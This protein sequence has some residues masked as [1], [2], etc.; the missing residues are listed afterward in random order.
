MT[1]K[2]ERMP[3]VAFRIMEMVFRIIDVFSPAEE[4]LDG[5]DI[6]NGDI[7]VDYGC[8]PGR[9][10]RRASELVGKNG[11]VYAVDIHELAIKAVKKKIDR[12]KLNNVMAVNVKGYE[13]GIDNKS[14]DLIYALD[15]FHMINNPNAF[16]REIHRVLKSTGRLIIDDGHQKRVVSREKINGS[17]IWKI[18]KENK[19]YLECIPI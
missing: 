5:F 6:K 2:A 16:L 19:E 9:Y 18:E 4:R 17:K 13:C 12:Y 10:I 11:M 1:R 3:D 7:I 14:V 15:V 8:G